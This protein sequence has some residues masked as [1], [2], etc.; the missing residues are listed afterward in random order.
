MS[1]VKYL[2][3]KV[4]RLQYMQSCK[5]C[6]EKGIFDALRDLVPFAKFKKREKHTWRS[7]TF[8]NLN[9]SF[10]FK[11]HIHYKKATNF[12]ELL[13]RDLKPINAELWKHDEHCRCD[14]KTNTCKRRK[15]IAEKRELSGE[16][17]FLEEPLIRSSENWGSLFLVI[18]FER[19]SLYL[20][21][22]ASAKNI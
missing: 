18:N 20:K 22:S 2:C 6:W 7:V 10:Q 3:R 11:R 4:V 19:S 17:P 12:M 5:L 16:N 21:L 13:A 9:C 8:S 14:V 1:V 15:V